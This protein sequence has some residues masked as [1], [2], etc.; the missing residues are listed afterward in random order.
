MRKLRKRMMAAM[1]AVMAISMSFPAMANAGNSGRI[2]RFTENRWDKENGK[3][4]DWTNLVWQF[5]N[6][7][8]AT[9]GTGPRFSDVHPDITDPEYYLKQY[10]YYPGEAHGDQKAPDGTYKSD[11]SE[12]LPVLQKF[13]QESDWIHKTEAERFWYLQDYLELGRHGNEYGRPEGGGGPFE[14]LTTHKGVCGD[15]ATIKQ[16]LAN[17]MGLEAVT[18][19]PFQD[20][21]IT[22]IK[23]NGQWLYADSTSST[24]QNNPPTS[25][26]FPVDFDTEYK[27]YEREYFA[28]DEYKTYMS[29]AQTQLSLQENYWAGKITAMEYYR[30]MYKNDGLTDEQ[31]KALYS[32]MNIDWNGYWKE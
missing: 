12:Y 21:E 29:Q 18:D 27:R 13:L 22:L 11:Y 20:H 23:V 3:W 28:S 24:P 6:G 5:E 31:I 10:V 1:A 9:I 16:R 30:E 15:Y 14:V 26:V 17:Y 2:D 32:D 19:V 4:S 7:E 25:G 8:I